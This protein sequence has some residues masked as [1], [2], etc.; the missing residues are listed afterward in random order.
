MDNPV[1]AQFPMRLLSFGA[2]GEGDEVASD[3]LLAEA[4][5]AGEGFAEIAFNYGEDRVY[6]AFRVADL[7]RAIKEM[8]P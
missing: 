7:R 8:T 4:T 2:A 5:D 6:I 3:M 1:S